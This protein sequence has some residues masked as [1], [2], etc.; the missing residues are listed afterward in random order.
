MISGTLIERLSAFNPKGIF[1]RDWLTTIGTTLY[2]TAAFMLGGAYALYKPPAGGGA[3]AGV[4]QD[5][6]SFAIRLVLILVC[7]SGA[8]YW[9]LHYL[10]FARRKDR[11]HANS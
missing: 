6:Q 10:D 2:T 11:S 4:D 9:V 8:V 3:L 5:I 1:A 7:V